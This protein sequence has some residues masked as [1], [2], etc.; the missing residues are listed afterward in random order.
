MPE[1]DL[2]TSDLA[3]GWIS[4][5]VRDEI[6]LAAAGDLADAIEDVFSNASANLVVDLKETDF[7]DSTGPEALVTAQRRFQE[8]RR[9][10]A[11][12]VDGG[13]VSR[14]VDL[15]GIESAIR[16]VPSPEDLL[17]DG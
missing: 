9:G 15:S 16:V 8:N 4:L 10:F 7:M 14:L 1:L 5:A 11:L 3:G 6:D 12:A 13:P 17:T 2:E